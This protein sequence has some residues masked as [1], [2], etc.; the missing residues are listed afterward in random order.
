[1]TKKKLLLILS[2]T[3]ACIMEMNARHYTV[4][5]ASDKSPVI[6][7]TVIGSTGVIK[8]LTDN[9]G[10]I[11]VD[12]RELPITIQCIGY[13][14]ATVSSP[15]DTIGM[16]AAAYQLNEVV[17]TPA[18][19]PIKRILCFA[20]EYSS[21]ITGA[22]TMQYYCEY[23]AVAFVTDGKVKGYRSFDSKPH[24][25]SARRYARIKK[26]D[27]DSVFK[28]KWD[29]DITDLSWFDFMA[30][31]PD[32]K[33]EMPKAL[34]DGEETDTVPG[35]YGPKFIYL[36]KNGLFTKKADVLSD[37]KNRKWSP[38]LF[39]LIGMTSDI[40]AGTWTLSFADNGSNTFGVNEFISGTYNIHLTGKGKWLKKAFNTKEPIEMDAYMELYPIEITNLTVEEYKEMREDYSSIPFRYPDGIMPLSP[41]IQALV[42]RLD[43]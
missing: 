6:G 11:D 23:M 10:G 26:S 36:K 1:M 33:V 2:L 24:E 37:H 31:L 40:T 21:G 3:L 14:P 16:V 18:D 13:L 19:R 41:A 25:K 27:I 35:K 30:F 38:L 8:G 39:K 7:A 28:P 5:D 15:A 32:K 42:T 20:R 4:T 34:I 29:E 43:N 9:D 22:D 12:G 17:F